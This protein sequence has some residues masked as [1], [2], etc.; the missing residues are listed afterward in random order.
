MENM[1]GMRWLVVSLFCVCPL[2]MNAQSVEE[3][4][5]ALDAYDY[6]TPI[7]QIA[8]ESGDSLLTPLRAKALKAMN[9]YWEARKEWESLLPADSAD[10]KILVELGECYR[11]MSRNELA[12]LCYGKSL[13]L[14][15]D[16]HFF[17]Q[18]HVRTLLAAENYEAAHDA[19]YAW[20]VK[21]SLSAMG[22]KYLGMACE[23]LA[24]NDQTLFSRMSYSYHKAYLLNPHD[25]Q[26]VAHLAAIYNAKEQYSDA[27]IVTESYRRF[28]TGNRD[29]NRQNAK[30]YCMMKNYDKAVERY[31][32]LKASGDMSFTTLYYLGISCYGKKWFHEAEKHLS[33]AQQLRPSVPAD[34]S[35]L[36]HLAKASSHASNQERGVALMKEA[37]EMVKPSDNL[38][39]RLYEGLVDC[40]SRWEDGDPYDKIEVMKKTYDLNKEYTLFYKIAEI[41]NHQKDY[42]NAVY[43]Y[44]KFMSMVPKDKQGPLD[45]NGKPKAGW[46]SLYWEASKKLEKIKEDSF[47]RGEVK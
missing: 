32:E 42:D 39:K 35:L 36:Y 11:L 7:V 3:M 29:V 6:E 22:Y 33:E 45:E 31:T 28:D 15:P 9:R 17:R 18:Q 38:V 2:W 37:I 5:K 43:Y 1:Y 21:D 34:V 16:N 13:E 23:G 40:Y 41:Y 19:A 47:F 12:A 8:P 20:V 4:Q 30:A 46:R 27:V 26:T 24:S 25:G 44:E 14:Y 10:V